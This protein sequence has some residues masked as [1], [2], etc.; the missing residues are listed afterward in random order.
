MRDNLEIPQLKVL[1]D[2]QYVADNLALDLSDAQ[3]ADKLKRV[4]ADALE[5]EKSRNL[6][7]AIHEGVRVG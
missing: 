6:D 3:A 5:S 7:N 1:E 4:I 2:I